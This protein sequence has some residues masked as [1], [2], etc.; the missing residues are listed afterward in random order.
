MPFDYFATAIRFITPYR[1]IEKAA[2]SAAHHLIKHVVTDKHNAV[3]LIQSWNGR[4][5]D[6]G[7]FYLNLSR[8][9]QYQILKFW[10]LAD[11]A[12]DKYAATIQE[13]EMATL[14]LDPPESVMWPSELLKFFYNHG[15]ME[16]C[17]RGISLSHL[18]VGDKCY[19]NSSNWADY[20][21]S[22]PPV[23]Q[24]K[25]LQQISEYSLEK[26]GFNIECSEMKIELK[27]MEISECESRDYLSFTSSIYINGE[28]V[29]TAKNDGR[30]DEPWITSIP[31]NAQPLINAAEK[32]CLENFLK[33][34]SIEFCEYLTPKIAFIKHIN[35][36]AHHIDLTRWNEKIEKYMG[37]AFVIGWPPVTYRIIKSPISIDKLMSSEEGR[38][39]LAKTIKDLIIPQLAELETILNTNIPKE[40]LQE[41]YP[42]DP[43]RISKNLKE[44]KVPSKKKRSK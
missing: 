7:D 43:S 14:F 33:T 28:Y 23:E 15:I 19:G 4:Q 12:G 38:K 32:Y 6:F 21:L 16:E 42:T 18:P 36:L 40:F 17:E 22:L 26:R 13:N 10:G 1:E 39:L 2:K 25:V 34:E 31:E 8:L 9:T 44:T 3:H 30:S 24:K 35:E 29:G 27:N 11:P 41:L 37:N 20:I 5:Q